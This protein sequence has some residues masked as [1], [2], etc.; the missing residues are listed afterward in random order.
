MHEPLV[1]SQYN[2]HTYYNFRSYLAAFPGYFFA[3]EDT[4]APEQVVY[5]ELG[6]W[7]TNKQICSPP[8][9]PIDSVSVLYDLTKT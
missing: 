3:A 2:I 8:K 6:V 1:H 5:K 7:S 4:Q 9:G